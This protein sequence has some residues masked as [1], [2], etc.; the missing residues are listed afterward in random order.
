MFLCENGCVEM[1]V[2]KGVL[3]EGKY[4][5]CMESYYCTG[6]YLLV[7]VHQCGLIEDVG[8]VLCVLYCV[9]LCFG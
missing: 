2:Q 3:L 1:C 9:C 4:V 5:C 8:W 7:I 6:E